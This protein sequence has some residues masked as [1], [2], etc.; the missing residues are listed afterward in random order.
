M[1]MRRMR[2]DDIR[3]NSERVIAWFRN[4][5]P[6]GL[7]TLVGI[8][9]IIGGAFGFLPILGFW[10]IPLGLA[11]L[12]LDIRSVTRWLRGERAGSPEAPKEQRE[13]ASSDDSG[14]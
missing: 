7:R 10:M 9:F 13:R 12:M 5:V 2:I 6:P 4:S 14:E 3:R 11:I 1:Y 8:L